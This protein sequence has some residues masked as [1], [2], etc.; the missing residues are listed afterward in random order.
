MGFFVAIAWIILAFVLASTAMNKGRSFG[1][2]LALGLI[3][4]PIIGFIVLIAIGDNKEVLQQQNIAR[5]LTKK[6]PFCAN[7]IKQEAIVCQYC[8]RDLPK[9][10][11]EIQ[12]VI[13]EPVKFDA[14]HIVIRETNLN[15]SL[16][17]HPK[18]Y[19]ILK[20]GE[21]VRVQNMVDRKNDLGGIW[22]LITT[23]LNEEGWCLSEA[24]SDNL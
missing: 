10:H 2:F 17:L 15:D 14:T 9:E 7:E 3:F 4:S 16:S 5:G 12:R 19:R 6:C 20:D 13:A 11:N 21:K 24:L 8:G 22:A 18:T 23:E 1:A